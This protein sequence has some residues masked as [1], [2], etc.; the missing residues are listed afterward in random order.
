MLLVNTPNP[1]MCSKTA[2]SRPRPRSS[3]RP[4]LFWVIWVSMVRIRVSVRVRAGFG[5]IVRV[6]LLF[7]YFN[8]RPNAAIFFFMDSL[9]V[10]R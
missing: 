6:W 3:P 5:V 1:G 9:Q 2:P 4:V 8:H 10:E 7:D